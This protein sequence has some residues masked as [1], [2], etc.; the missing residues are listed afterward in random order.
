MDVLKGRDFDACVFTEHSIPTSQQGL[1]RSKLGS[2]YKVDLSN[3]DPEKHKNVGGTGC[4]LN[5]KTK[6]I[7]KPKPANPELQ[8]ALDE[9]RCG[10]YASGTAKN[11]FVLTYVV[12]GWP[13]GE[14]D[15]LAASRTDD[16]LCLISVDMAMHDEGPKIVVGDLNGPINRFPAFDG[17][18]QDGHLFDVGAIASAFGGIDGD[19]TCKANSNSKPTRRDYII[20]NRQAKDQILTMEV[21]HSIAFPVHDVLRVAFK[22][23]VPLRTYNAVCLPKPIRQ[24]FDEKCLKYYGEQNLAAHRNKVKEKEEATSNRTITCDI[25]IKEQAVIT[26]GPTYK[27]T[28]LCKALEQDQEL[29]V[30]SKTSLEA[31]IKEQQDKDIASNFTPAQKEAQLNLLHHLI[32]KQLGSH[33][34]CWKKAP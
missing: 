26:K 31:S 2:G 1:A 7:I 32:D 28:Y 13:N 30:G 5:T 21:D 15:D 22:D 3:L 12:Y 19:N 24:L 16:L 17:L 4:I 11:N 10:L 27:S 20:A 6:N 34:K 18:I 33:G 8:Q 23:S 14:C 9:G 29:I 25:S